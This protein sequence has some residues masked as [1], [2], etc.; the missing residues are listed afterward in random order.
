MS[1]EVSFN[2]DTSRFN[3]MARRLEYRLK[4]GMPNVIRAE[5]GAVLKACFKRTKF[6]TEEEV[7]KSSRLRNAKAAT[8]GTWGASTRR[9][10]GPERGQ[11]YVVAGMRDAGSYGN[12]WLR[13]PWGNGRNFVLV[14]VAGTMGNATTGEGPKRIGAATRAKFESARNRWAAGRSP[15]LKAGRGA[16]GLAKQSWLQIALDLNINLNGVKGGG[17]ISKRD[18][19]RASHALSVK[20]KR[21]SNGNGS[22]ANDGHRF[23]IT[24]TNTLPYAVRIGMD[25]TLQSVLIGRAKLFDQLIK[26]GLGT[27]LDAIKKAFPNL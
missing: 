16:I 6:A 3:E 7:D 25:R 14:A 26:R 9:K 5:A 8:A 22:E 13:S 1:G 2:V 27:D 18:M 4:I 20:G 10:G 21:Y 19:A 11:G 12:M 23:T 15:E 24:L 17:P